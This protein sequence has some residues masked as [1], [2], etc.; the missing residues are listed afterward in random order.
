MLGRSRRNEGREQDDEAGVNAEGLDLWPLISTPYMSKI[1]THR[2]PLGTSWRACRMDLCSC[3]ARF[4]ALALVPP[5]QP[6]TS[7]APGR[8]G[9]RIFDPCP[10]I[11]RPY[12]RCHLSPT[13]PWTLSP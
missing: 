8:Y 2:E 9:L 5:L 1:Q 3:A 13:C 12:R 7:S 4:F 10:H 11:L 6:L